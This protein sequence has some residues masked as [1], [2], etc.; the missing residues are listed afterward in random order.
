VPLNPSVT[1]QN[2]YVLA[3]LNCQEKSGSA[4]D[5]ALNLE[6]SIRGNSPSFY[7]FLQSSG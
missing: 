2:P 4:T 6:G 7:I 1:A 5:S 3:A